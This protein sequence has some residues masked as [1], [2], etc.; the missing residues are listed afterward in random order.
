MLPVPH[1]KK[2]DHIHG[3][4]AAREAGS[5]LRGNVTPA[6][7]KREAAVISGAASCRSAAAAQGPGTV[8]TEPVWVIDMATPTSEAA[9][10]TDQKM[11]A[12]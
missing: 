4:H 9:I 5:I 10:S 6:L 12:I 7:G 3:R 2:H 1:V 11:I 8:A